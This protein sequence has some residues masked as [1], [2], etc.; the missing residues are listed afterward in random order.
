MSSPAQRDLTDFL[1]ETCTEL[2]AEV[3]RQ[4]PEHV[5]VLFRVAMMSGMQMNLNATLQVLLEQV[6]AIV[7]FE[8][9]LV[10]F[11]NR[12]EERTL[13]RTADGIPNGDRDHF[14]T[15]NAIDSW[16]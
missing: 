1:L 13:L 10:Y 15:Q 2:P 9:A 7:A 3:V 4:R 14:V 11:W 6:R 5:N 8:K 16:I 12:N